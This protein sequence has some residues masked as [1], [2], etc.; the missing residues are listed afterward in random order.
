MREAFDKY[1][2][3]ELVRNDCFVVVTMTDSKSTK[4]S[5]TCMELD[6]P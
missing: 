4:G 1:W 5:L 2:Y 6:I 3:K